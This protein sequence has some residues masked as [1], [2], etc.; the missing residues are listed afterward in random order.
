MKKS[1]EGPTSPRTQ[2]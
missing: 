1:L 2:L